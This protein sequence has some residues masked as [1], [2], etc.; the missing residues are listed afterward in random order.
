MKAI[1][2]IFLVAFL[3]AGMVGCGAPPTPP[4]ETPVVTGSHCGPHLKNYDETRKGE[5]WAMIQEYSPE[6]AFMI[7][8]VRKLTTERCGKPSELFVSFIKGENKDRNYNMSIATSVHEMAH[9]FSIWMPARDGSVGVTDKSS[10]GHIAIY[11]AGK[12]VVYIPRTKTFSA[13]R[14]ASRVPDEL[15]DFTYKTY[16]HTDTHVSSVTG[17]YGLLNEF[18]A[19]YHDTRTTE[20]MLRSAELRFF[21]PT[22]YLN[23]LYFKYY[24]L[25]YLAFAREQ[26]RE[27]FDGLLANRIFVETFLDLHDRFEALHL[28]HL[29]FRSR[30]VIREEGDFYKFGE[31]RFRVPGVDKTYAA[32]TRVLDQEKFKN[33]MALLRTRRGAAD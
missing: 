26:E 22:E 5:A 3:F 14:I 19:Y 4:R 16:I 28:A 27:I 2:R 18:H 11:L 17:V 32:L 6:G 33:L 25:E 21:A 8:E 1:C 12:G 29:D 9:V 31:M 24:I 7:G 15:R 10:Y 13:Q 20:R 30:N 23:F